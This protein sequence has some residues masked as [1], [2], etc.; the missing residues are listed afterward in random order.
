MILCLSTIKWVHLN[1]GD[2]GLKALF[3]KIKEQLVPGGLLI[4]EP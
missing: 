2:T 1:F 4:V 3:L